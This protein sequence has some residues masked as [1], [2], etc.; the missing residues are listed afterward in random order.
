MQ[1]SNREDIEGDKDIEGIDVNEEITIYDVR[2][3]FK[4]L[5]EQIDAIIVTDDG[6]AVPSLFVKHIKQRTLEFLDSIM[7]DINHMTAII[8]ANGS[9]YDTIIAA[10]EQWLNDDV[11]EGY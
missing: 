5:K 1:H 10:T 3:E 2:A 6:G 11:P 4:T 7:Q 8:E 9:D